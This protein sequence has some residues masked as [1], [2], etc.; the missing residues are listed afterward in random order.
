MLGLVVWVSFL[1]FLHPP[2]LV[3]FG[4]SRLLFSF[5]C[6][7]LPSVTR[8]WKT[9]SLCLPS[10]DADSSGKPCPPL[11]P[12]ERL[13]SPLTCSVS[14]VPVSVNGN[15]ILLFAQ[16]VLWA[17][18]EDISRRWPGVPTP[19]LSSGLAPV[20]TCLAGHCR[21]PSGLFLLTRPAVTWTTL[22][23][24]SK[25]I[26]L[27]PQHRTRS[28]PRTSQFPYTAPRFEMPAL[29]SVPVHCSGTH[30]CQRGSVGSVGHTLGRS[31]APR[32]ER[33]RCP[34]GAFGPPSPSSRT[35]PASHTTQRS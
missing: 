32:Q 21:L 2:D 24:A 11:V 5:L 35:P 28:L 4:V 26:F 17:L 9:Q 18:P 3:N 7:H 13:P 6:T 27:V 15:S 8:P 33:S 1:V 29:A 25:C 20:I 10:P 12:M 14:A 31:R 23:L 22:C 30:T 19:R 16:Q 34:T